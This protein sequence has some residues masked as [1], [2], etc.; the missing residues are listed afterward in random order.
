MRRI[1]SE[2][3][4]SVGADARAVAVAR[5]GQDAKAGVPSAAGRFGLGFA[6]TYHITD[7]PSFVSGPFLVLFDP[8]ACNLPGASAAHPGL[9]INFA[10]GAPS[11][12]L[13]DR[14]PDTVAPL[15]AFGCDMRS[16]FR[17]ACCFFFLLRFA[18]LLPR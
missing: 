2:R 18:S 16:P 1:A 4:E 13:A 6:S 3:R 12:Q 7:V 14:F 9:K 15:K 17:G 5:I 8:H 10:G 11:C